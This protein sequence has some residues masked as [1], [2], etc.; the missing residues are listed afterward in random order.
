MDNSVR[1]VSVRVPATTANLGPGFDCLGLALDIYNGVSLEESEASSI[2]VSGEGS[3][4]LS[5]TANNL[6]FKA[7]SLVYQ[8]A[9]KALPRLRL[10]CQ[11]NIPL[12]RGLGSSAAAVVGGLV[13]ANL[14]C[15]KPLSQSQILKLAWRLEGHP[16]NVAPA[17]LGGCRVTVL[18]R[19]EVISI[20]I[21]VP[22]EL[23]AVLF[24]PDFEMS[25]REARAVLPSEISRADA[26]FNIGRAALLVAAL[27]TGQLDCLKLATQDRLHQPA[28]QTLFPTMGM[29]FEAA[30]GAGALGVFLS[31]AGSTILALT[32]NKAS[33]I[34]QAMVEAAAVQNISGRA[35]IAH[36]S[37]AGAQ[38]M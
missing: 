14:L 17:L 5:R 15:G 38:A 18:D 26:I 3:K 11:N 21:P 7:V 6:V 22:P 37:L 12:K 32:V 34:A 9:G 29:L 1:K 19:D 33:T 4:T 28:R 20:S 8:E 24:I 16:D 35:M 31:G 36:P 13:A 30:L 25:T 2:I 23:E 27:T 10:S